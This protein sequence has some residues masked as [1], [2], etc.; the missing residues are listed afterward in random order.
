MVKRIEKQFINNILFIMIE[1]MFVTRIQ[2]R[3]NMQFLYGVF[4]RGNFCVTIHNK[5]WF[6]Y[7]NCVYSL[8][9]LIVYTT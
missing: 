8:F 6:M 9:F 7:I 1:V 3:I 4:Y 5:V 2:I